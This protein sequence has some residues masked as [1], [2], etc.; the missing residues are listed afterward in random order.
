MRLSCW[1]RLEPMESD[2]NNSRKPSPCGFG[3]FLEGRDDTSRHGVDV[4][5]NPSSRLRER[6]LID[7]KQQLG[8]D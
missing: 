2:S 5:S 7:A 4:V 1:S 6:S 8:T 3:S